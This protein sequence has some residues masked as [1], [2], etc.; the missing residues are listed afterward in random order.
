[1]NSSTDGD[2]VMLRPYPDSHVNPMHTLVRNVWHLHGRHSCHQM[3]WRINHSQRQVVHHQSE[4]NRFFGRCLQKLQQK[5]VIV[6]GA[7]S[8]GHMKAKKFRLAEG[9]VA[10][11]SQD[12]AVAEVRNDMLELNQKV[13]SSLESRGLDVQIISSSSVG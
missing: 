12:E 1:M 13:V 7:G 4:R 8:F 9:R 3:G 6:H 10:G 2:S 5:L 11:L